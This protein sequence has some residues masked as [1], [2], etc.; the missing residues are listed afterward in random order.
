M[1]SQLRFC[2][3]CGYRMGEGPA[4]YT[5]TV[6]FQN[7]RPTAT[8][9]NAATA[10][11]GAYAPPYAAGNGQVA[12]V[13][14][15]PIRCRK[16][17][18]SGMSWIFLAIVMFFIAGGS[19]SFFVPKM[20]RGINI[21]VPAAVSTRS[22]VGVDQFNTTEGGVTFGDVEPP[23][24]PADKAGLV[25]GDVITTF[26]NQRVTTDDEMMDLLGKTPIG[27]TVEV[28]FIRDGETKTT[29]LTTVSKADFDQLVR[30]FRSR[31]QSQGRLGAD[32][33]DRVEVPGTKLHG[34][35][36][37]SI[38][39][40]L[41][42]DMAGLKSG[43]IVIEFDGIPIRT[44]EELTSRIRRAVPYSTVTIVVMRGTERLEI[45]VKMGR[46]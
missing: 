30:D 20:R 13:A 46:R 12:T 17:R 16:R 19:L 34:V 5:E 26:D 42:A 44:P 43:D 18:L 36:L 3:N 23:G 8:A 38:S 41:P 4:E 45:P 24:S 37:G 33:G 28:V 14:A 10:F 32:I 2:R 25:G 21:G 35:R 7:G 40:S 29:K 27:K 9:A 31:P 22:W 15:G 6:R 11:P 1:P 39:S